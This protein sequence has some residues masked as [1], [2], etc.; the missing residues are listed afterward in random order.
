MKLFGKAAISDFLDDRIVYRNLVPVDKRLP[1]LATLGPQV[2]LTP[3][4][5]P[6]KSEPDYARLIVAL[7]QQASGIGDRYSVSSKQYSVNGKRSV[8]LQSSRTSGLSS[9]IS[10]FL[11]ITVWFSVRL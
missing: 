6:R 5:V 2:G 10:A 4:R 1:D 11:L 9:A 3:G 8:E 7:L